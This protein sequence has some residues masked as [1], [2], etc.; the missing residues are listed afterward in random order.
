MSI[1][2]V[3]PSIRKECH[4]QFVASWQKLFNYYN[5][6]LLTVWDGDTPTL[7]LNGKWL[8]LAESFV[9]DDD[10]CLFYNKTDSCRNYGFYYTARY[11]DANY[12]YTLDDDC[13]LI[14][15]TDPI[16]EHLSV[17][18]KRV[19]LSWMNTGNGLH[20]PYFRGVPYEVRNEGTITV[21]HGIWDE[22]PD[23]DSATQLTLT[24]NINPHP[25]FYQGPIPRGVLAPICGMNVMFT[26]A[27]LPD[28]YYAPM[29]PQVNLHRFGD[30]WWGCS[31][32]REL[33]KRNETVYTGLAKIQHSRASDVFKNLA[34][35]AEG[36]RLNEKWW[37]EG[38]SINPY[39]DLYNKN[40]LQYKQRL[41]EILNIK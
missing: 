21:S 32:L 10:K 34:A 8:G 2:V 13:L 16:A 33:W 7:E 29:G 4:L 12:V 6:K 9:D 25:N 24:G 27:M 5:I 15:G 36:L 22:V 40:R 20:T 17:L 3:V 37:S 18:G 1:V 28:V 23:L 38:D 26:R 19:P 31:L 35:E 30:I 41:S 11:L 39:F 14:P